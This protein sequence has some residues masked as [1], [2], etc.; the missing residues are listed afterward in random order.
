MPSPYD[1]FE[2]V[3]SGTERVSLCDVVD[4]PGG[5]SAKDRM[6]RWLDETVQES[7]FEEMR[8][9][10]VD[11]IRLPVGYWNFITYPGHLSNQSRSFLE[12][13]FSGACSPTATPMPPFPPFLPVPGSSTPNAPDDVA[14]RLRNLQTMASPPPH[15]YP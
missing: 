11:V 4:L 7:H 14:E 6:L 10:G 12:T 1:F 9:F 5:L 13:S 3:T 2:G 15:S 8:S